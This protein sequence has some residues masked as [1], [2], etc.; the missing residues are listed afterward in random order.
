MVKDKHILCDIQLV[1]HDRNFYNSNKE[2]RARNVG[3]EKHE[4]I[5]S[6]FVGVCVFL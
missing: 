4:N 5:P 6:Y 3:Y 1:M 2:R